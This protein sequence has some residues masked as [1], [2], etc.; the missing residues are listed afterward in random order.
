M[1]NTYAS[2]MVQTPIIGTASV[3]TALTTRT[4][5]TGT[6][7][8]TQLTAV[9]ATQ[10]TRIDAIQ[11]QAAATTAA[12]IIFVWLY[13]GVTA[14]LMDE[15]PMSG[16]TG[17]ATVLGDNYTRVYQGLTVPAGSQLY[18][19]VTVTQNMNVFCRGGKF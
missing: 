14:R 13:D 16:T 2:P 11:I 1:A 6:T 15:I 17:S 10:P 19:S 9:D 3:T 12:C 4:N 8:I 18:T 7:G 5:I